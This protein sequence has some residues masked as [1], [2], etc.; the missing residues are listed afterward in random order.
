MENLKENQYVCSMD[1]LENLDG[2]Y[3]TRSVY[4]SN[5]E[6]DK[7]Q[8]IGEADESKRRVKSL[9]TFWADQKKERKKKIQ[10]MIEF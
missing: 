7:K 1:T 9:G 4:W 8:E 10:E 6:K 5:I 2:A 3:F